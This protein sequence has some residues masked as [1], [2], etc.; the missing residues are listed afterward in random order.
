MGGHQ[1]SPVKIGVLPSELGTL[2]NVYINNRAGKD[3]TLDIRGRNKIASYDSRSKKYTF[4]E[5]PDIPNP[6]KTIG[7]QWQGSGFW[8]RIL[9][10][11]S[12]ANLTP[13]YNS[14]DPPVQS[15]ATPYG[16]TPIVGFIRYWERNDYIYKNQNFTGE[17]YLAS[18]GSDSVV[19]SSNYEVTRSRKSFFRIKPENTVFIVR[20]QTNVLAVNGDGSF[21]SN[22]ANSTS[23]LQETYVFPEMEDVFSR[24][25][26]SL[27][28]N[29]ISNSNT[30]FYAAAAPTHFLNSNRTLEYL[31]GDKVVA[32][33]TII[34]T[35]S[36]FTGLTD[37]S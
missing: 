14:P 10:S 22:S 25:V 23:F 9:S 4:V 16:F 35:D 20:D 7:F 21:S 18:T 36:T 13:A 19:D 24:F 34:E 28:D 5:I 17:E 2:S 31:V 30:T 26:I 32:S 12:N 15:F 37:I 3:F 11:Y 6:E 1:R 27:K 33:K 8:T 29:N